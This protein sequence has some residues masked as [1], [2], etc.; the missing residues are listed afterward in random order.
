MILV[1]DCFKLV[2]G[3]GK[4]IGIYNL[5]LNLVV[6]LVE[7]KKRNDNKEIQKWEIIV[8]GT[9]LNR[10]DF[11]IPGVKFIPIK[12]SPLKKVNCVLWELLIV[13]FICRKLN[14][15]RVLFPRGFCALTHPIKDSIIVHDLIPFY[16]NKHY[17]GFF[18]KMENM[19]IMWRLK[20]SII[21]CDQVITVSQTSK[22][23]IINA[24]K[25][26][27]NNIIVIGNG[28]NALASQVKE[29]YAENYMIAITSDLPHKNA[30]G[31]I[32]SYEEYWKVSKKPLPLKIIGIA[33]LDKYELPIYIKDKI[34]NYKFIKEDSE[35]HKMIANAK[36]FIFLSLTEGFGFPPIE[37]MQL[38]VPVICSNLSSL[39]EVVGDAAI[40]VDPNDYKS[41]GKT[42]DDLVNS[43]EK[44]KAL[45]SKGYKN[46][47]RFSWE[48]GVKLY[49]KALIE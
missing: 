21:S 30:V 47:S 45:V 18:N 38:G 7:G 34:T 25:I 49:W 37:A 1:I 22:K 19:Y 31:I 10:V 41:I 5:A 33:D 17:P 29:E 39:P 2:K 28:C 15:D 23:D 16:Y 14:A 20:S 11:E 35:L 24:T 44:Q 3:I 4:S 46:I 40:M 32:K 42:I 27:A 12:Y 8:L 9:D 43:E 13:S 6:N 48:S 36:I 26:E